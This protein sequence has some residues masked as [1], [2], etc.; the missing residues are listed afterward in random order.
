MQLNMTKSIFF[1]EING[2]AVKSYPTTREI[3]M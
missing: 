2:L 3:S 1:N